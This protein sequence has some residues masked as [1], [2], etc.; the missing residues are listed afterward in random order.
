MIWARLFVSVAV[1]F[2]VG[3]FIVSLILRDQRRENSFLWIRIWL[4]VGMG[5]GITSIHYFLWRL[6]SQ[7]WNKWFILSELVILVI[8]GMFYTRSG[9]LRSDFRISS[10][11]LN[12]GK[13][14]FSGWLFGATIIFSISL[15]G[16]VFFK[17]PQGGWDAWMIWNLHA[18]FL[19]RGSAFWQNVFST[20][21]PH[22]DYPMMIPANVAR[23]WSWMGAE[24]VYAPA[25]VGA[26]FTFSIVGLLV[27]GI[28]AVR[29]PD[30]GYLAGLM[31]LSAPAFHVHGPTQA[32][33]FPLAYFILGSLVLLMIYETSAA[34]GRANIIMAGIFA[35]FSAWTKNEG[36]LF[37]LAL[38]SSRAVVLLF[39]RELTKLSREAVPFLVGLAPVLLFIFLYKITFAPANDLISAQ[40]AE[41]WTRLT[42][43]T[44]Y[45]TIG[46]EFLYQLFRLDAR[47]ST[48][49]FL[50]IIV[51]VVY[52]VN[53][54]F[55]KASGVL[56]AILTSLVM[57]AGYFL[58]FVI[59]YF[60]IPWHLYTAGTRL[61]I[62]IW[63]AI[64][65]A[66]SMMLA[67]RDQ[68]P[69]VQVLTSAP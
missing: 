1:T 31:L 42:D 16:L 18:R 59:T 51:I 60:E 66:L 57:L 17:I 58:V 44:R 50:L 29:G 27:S 46:K 26:A 33:D 9:Q 6:I 21:L 38:I 34:R 53:L 22:P 36:F 14:R 10:M 68:K 37:I 63:A 15:Y 3:F 32:S 5:F 35:A 12:A 25:T 19:Y 41:T 65:L 43:P 40:G 30:R 24:S 56:T 11:G 52:R 13:T 39:K 48:P 54:D 55:F 64:V 62:H 28:R 4:G 69:S 61:F 8:L 49:F 47:F 7:S 45:I 2:L 23:A 67:D 20:L